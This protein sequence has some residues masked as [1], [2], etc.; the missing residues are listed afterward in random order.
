MRISVFLQPTTCS[1][2]KTTPGE[3]MLPPA[4]RHRLSGPQAHLMRTYHTAKM[5]SASTALLGRLLLFR[6]RS[7]RGRPGRRRSGP[8]LVPLVELLLLLLL[9]LR[10]ALLHRRSLPD[11]GMR[12]LRSRPCL[13]LLWRMGVAIRRLGI[14]ILLRL[15]VPVLGRRSSLLLVG[16]RLGL[17]HLVNLIVAAVGLSEWLKAVLG[18]LRPSAL[19]H[20]C[21]LRGTHRTNQRLLIQMSARLSLPLLDRVRQRRRRS[22]DNHRPAHDGCRRSHGHR[23]SSAHHA[24]ADRFFTNKVAHRRGGDLSRIHLHHIA[25]DRPGIDES[26]VR[27][28]CHAV[29]HVLIDVS[30][31]VDVCGSVYDHSVVNVRDLRDIHRC[32]GDVH[33]VHIGATDAVSGKVDFTGSEREP[34]HANADGEAEARTAAHECDQCRSPD[35]PDY[36]RSWH[37][38]PSAVHRRPAAI[39][40]RSESPR[41]IFDPGPAPRSDKDPV[42]EAI[43]SPSYDDGA[44]APAGT[45][46]GHIAP[47]AVFVEIFIAGHFARNI[48]RGVGVIFAIVAIEGPAIEIIPIGDLAEVVV[49]VLLVASKGGRLT[50]DDGEGKTTARNLAT[51]VPYVGD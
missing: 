4:L 35:G 30:D 20:L 34:S 39:V 19:I 29:V 24:R 18:L 44:R 43:R 11:Q 1:P 37:P 21:R 40:E 31:V 15:H 50:G 42:T 6:L 45:V 8:L 28:H 46:T 25:S 33:V 3:V 13:L 38:E 26:L 22:H 27:Y 49:E 14:A 41:L 23:P 36:D 7:P 12:L 32:V 51:A 17:R 2:Q 5:P 9:L 16:P 10:A 48:I 47:V